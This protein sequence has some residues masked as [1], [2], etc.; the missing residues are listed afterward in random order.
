VILQALDKLK[1]VNEVYPNALL[2]KV[3]G[4]TKA[5][6]LIEIFKNAG[7]EQKTRVIAVMS[8]LDPASAG[9]FAV[10]GY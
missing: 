3:F 10:L 9:K 4:N 5:T 2:V 7:R 6:E 8:K 1:D